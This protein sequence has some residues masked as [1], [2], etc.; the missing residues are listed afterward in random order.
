MKSLTEWHFRKLLKHQKRILKYNILQLKS[1][2]LTHNSKPEKNKEGKEHRQPRPGRQYD[3][4]R[5]KSTKEGK[6]GTLQNDVRT[7]A[8]KEIEQKTRQRGKGVTSW[9][10]SSVRRV[11]LR[12]TKWRWFHVSIFVRTKLMAEMCFLTL[13]WPWP[14]PLTKRSHYFS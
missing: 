13:L 1:T 7:N 4:R 12:R 6:R 8:Q 2:T 5:D 9:R 3:I 11:F 14:W 10:T